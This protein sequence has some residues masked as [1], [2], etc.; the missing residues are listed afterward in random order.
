VVTVVVIVIIGGVLVR[1]LCFPREERAVLQH[2][3]CIDRATVPAAFL[4]RSHRRARINA[5]VRATILMEQHVIA[6]SSI[7]TTGCAAARTACRESIHGTHQRMRSGYK[8]PPNI[9]QGRGTGVTHYK[10]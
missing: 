7:T 4:A 1:H 2:V 9:M 3:H 5:A 10:Q 6:S 8:L